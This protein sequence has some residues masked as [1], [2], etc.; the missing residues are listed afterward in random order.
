MKPKSQDTP[1]TDDLFRSRLDQIINLRHELVTLS[2][3]IDW[4]HLDAEAA[5]CYAE[6][7]RPGIPTRLMVGLQV[8]KHMFTLSDEEVC[9]RW[10]YDPYFQ[11][12]CGEAYFQHRF[13][14]ERSSLTHWRKR[15]GEAFCERLIQESLR[16]ACASQALSTRELRK[17]VVDTTVQPKAVTYPTEAKLRFRALIALVRLARKHGVPLRQSY[18]R[19]AKRALVMSGR[20]RHAKQMKRAR[21]QERFIQVRLGRVMRDLRRQIRDDE[22]KQPV[23]AEPLRK[24]GI[25]LRQHKDGPEKLYSWHATETECI[26]KGKVDKPYEFGCKVSIT[27][28][29]HP[30]KAGHFVVHA[31]ALHGR[32]YDGHT[33]KPVIAGVTRLTGIEP[34]R[35]LVDKGYRGHDY[36]HP[37]RVYRSGQKRGVTAAIKKEL[38]RRAVVE[39][40][41]GHLKNEGH[42]GRNYLKGIEGDKINV[43]RSKAGYNFR[44]LLKWLRLFFGLIASA[45]TKSFLRLLALSQAECALGIR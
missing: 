39:P 37:H 43:L 19:V 35:I 12:F 45:L 32:P 24:A 28:T 1:A 25:L 44:L 11:Y 29:V 34:Q 10:E 4:V 40:L 20:Y 36:E 17:V 2:N 13:P 3:R 16:V 23:F 27:T 7:G 42:L 22:A 9:A 18:V 14:I 8:L 38:K 30:A 15:V 41:I 26:G 21:R 6:D 5:P 31:Q 33:L